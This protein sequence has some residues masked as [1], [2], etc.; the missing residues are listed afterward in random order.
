MMKK[1]TW[2][3]GLGTS[4]LVTNMSTR[5]AWMAA[6]PVS[7]ATQ[8][9][10]NKIVKPAWTSTLETYGKTMPTYSYKCGEC[11]DLYTEVRGMNDEPK[12]KE[13]EQ[14]RKPL[15]RVYEVRGI[16][17]KGDGFYSIDKRTVI[18]TPMGDVY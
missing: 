17:F 6:L 10:T 18:E 8:L 16:S 2:R 15:L 9:A 12:V 3:Y 7:T 14:C 5:W 1:M 11:L 13:C 4:A